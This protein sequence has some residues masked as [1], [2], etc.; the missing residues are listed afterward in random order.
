MARPAIEANSWIAMR[1]RASDKATIMRAVALEQTNLTEFMLR[2]ALQEAQ[3][4]I[5]NHDQVKLT[6]RDSLAVLDLLENPPNPNERLRKAARR[7]PDHS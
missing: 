1:I 2:T 4:V 5:D 7:L 6:R 3:A